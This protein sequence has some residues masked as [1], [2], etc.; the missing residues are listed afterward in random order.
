MVYNLQTLLKNM[1]LRP[2][3]YLFKTFQ[4]NIFMHYQ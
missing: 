4:T 3:F 1:I 2:Q